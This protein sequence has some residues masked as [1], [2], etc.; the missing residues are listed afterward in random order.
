MSKIDEI[1]KLA[2]RRRPGRPEKVPLKSIEGEDISRADG[3]DGEFFIR[4]HDADLP[5]QEL[6]LGI[7]S[8]IEQ[9]EDGTQ[10]NY[11]RMTDAFRYLLDEKLLVAFRLPVIDDNGKLSAFEKKESDTDVGLVMEEFGRN[12]G[13]SLAGTL[14]KMIVDEYGLTDSLTAQVVEEAGNSQGPP[15]KPEGNEV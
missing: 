8:R 13:F 6:L 3:V 9:H 4:V 15:E 5:Q 10:N 7:S 14:W 2:K 11:T 1:L 12:V